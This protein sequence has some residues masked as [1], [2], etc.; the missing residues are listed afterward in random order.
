MAVRNWNEG[1]LAEGAGR[2]AGGGRDP[3]RPR[4]TE[5]NIT[6]NEN[7]LHLQSHCGDEPTVRRRRRVGRDGRRNG[8]SSR[9]PG[10]GAGSGRWPPAEDFRGLPRA[11]S[12]AGERRV[13]TCRKSAPADVP[14]RRAP[15]ASSGP[16]A[17]GPWAGRLVTTAA[18]PAQ[19]GRRTV[20]QSASRP[21]GIGDAPPTR[22]PARCLPPAMRRGDRRAGSAR[23]RDARR[24]RCVRRP[25]RRP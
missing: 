24:P 12:R 20:R 14:A 21:A 11:E 4:D 6:I 9:S 10:R 15:C 13:G 19:A 17:R 1:P 18:Q 16:A 22:S 7:Y 8:A 3:C 23:S 2:A 25:S 5:V